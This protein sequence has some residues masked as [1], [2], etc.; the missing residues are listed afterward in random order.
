MNRKSRSHRMHIPDD[1]YDMPRF[2]V[3]LDPGPPS[4]LNFDLS[5]RENHH[6]KHTKDRIGRGL[7]KS[8]KTVMGRETINLKFINSMNTNPNRTLDSLLRM[9]DASPDAIIRY[10]LFPLISTKVTQIRKKFHFVV[11]LTPFLCNSLCFDY[12][13]N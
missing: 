11:L 12:V 8:A 1:L 3:P 7:L 6:G 5:P 10:F 2:P 9:L 13:L 4:M